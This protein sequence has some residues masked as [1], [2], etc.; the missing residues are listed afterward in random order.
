MINKICIGSAQFGFDYGITNKTGKV[1]EN[2]VKKI[3]KRASELN[4]KY[5]DTAQAYKSSEEVIG[6]N[7]PLENEF[8]IISKL[9]PLLTKNKKEN[10]ITELENGFQ[11]SLKALRKKNIDSLLFHDPNDLKTQ[12]FPIILDWIESLK[13]RNLIKRVGLSIYSKIDLDR[14]NIRRFDLVQLPLSIYDQRLLNDGTIKFLREIGISVHIRSIFLQGLILNDPK[15]WPS[16]ISKGFKDHHQKLYNFLNSNKLNKLE[17]VMKFPFFVKDAE[18]VVLG[19]T[20]YKEFDQIIKIWNK[21]KKQK[22]TDINHFKKWE[23]TNF[24]DLD[25]RKW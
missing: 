1:K 12:S 6:G 9:S 22:D 21:L 16:N 11:R 24:N 17:E 23:W 19:I 4:I 18:A 2:E 5:I 20:S 3:L 8:K 13:D 25:P 14:I 7:T 15:N 10:L